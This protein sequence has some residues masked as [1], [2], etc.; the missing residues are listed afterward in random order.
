MNAR[1]YFAHNTPEGVDP[2]ARITTAGFPWM[3]WGESIAGGSA[4]PGPQ[5]ALA[6]LITD[7]GIPDLGHRLHLLGVGSINSGLTQVGIG[8]VQNGTGSLTNYYTIDSA[9][10]A[11]TRPFITGVVFNDLNGNG[12]YDAGEGLAANI[13]IS[14]VGTITAFATGGYSLQVNPGVYTVTAS[15]GGLAA[16]ETTTVALGSQNVRLNFTTQGIQGGGLGNQLNRVATSLAQSTES[17]AH[18]VTQAYQTYLKRSP[19]AAGLNY[20]VGLMAGGMSDER[21]EGTFI[22]SPE[23]IGQH[24]GTNGALGDRDVPGFPW[25]SAPGNRGRL[26]G[27]IAQRRIAGAD[28]GSPELRLQCG[29]RDDSHSGRLPHLPGP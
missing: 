9:A 23:Y 22:G 6:G 3:S 17:Y 28:S 4:Y 21:I 27:R 12:K 2:G 8:I 1:S 14:G 13:T 11:D 7:T 26:L 25:P 10:S 29:T 5:E 24:G 20:W 19:D 15:G 18:F 16:P